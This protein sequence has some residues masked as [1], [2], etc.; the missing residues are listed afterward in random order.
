MCFFSETLQKVG[1]GS[2]VGDV[3]P[4]KPRSPIHPWN[5]TWNLKKMVS[6]RNLPFQISRGW[7]SGSREIGGVY[8]LYIPGESKHFIWFRMQKIIC[9]AQL[10]QRSHPGSVLLVTRC[11]RKQSY[12]HPPQNQEIPSKR[13]HPK[14]KKIIFQSWIF[15]GLSNRGPGSWELLRFKRFG[16]LLGSQD[17]VQFTLLWIP[18]PP[19]ARR[20]ATKATVS[21][22]QLFFFEM[23][24][25]WLRKQK[26][27]GVSAMPQNGAMPVVAVGTMILWLYICG[28]NYFFSPYYLGKWCHL[29][30]I[31]FKFVETTS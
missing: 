13:D 30:S 29:T 20:A 10:S 8:I 5:F 2:C 22:W 21:A 3:S 9:L 28:F 19:E 15:G 23:C 12:V 24:Y 1:S 18:T 27:P 16:S 26:Q 25:L 31:F 17:L 6:K 7:C 11:E 4:I 14:R